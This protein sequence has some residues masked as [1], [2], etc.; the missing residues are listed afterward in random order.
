MIVS[1]SVEKPEESPTNQMVLGPISNVLELRRKLSEQKSF[2]QAASLTISAGHV[3]QPLV[4]WKRMLFFFS[5]FY[6]FS[7][8]QPLSPVYRF[9]S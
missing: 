5:L 2:Q 6:F 4:H 3:E 9:K 1:V 7:Y 8:L